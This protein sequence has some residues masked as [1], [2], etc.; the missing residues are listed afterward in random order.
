MRKL[1][2]MVTM[3][4]TMMMIMIVMAVCE[5]H[6]SE[7]VWMIWQA[8]IT[9]TYLHH[10]HCLNLCASNAK[11]SL[12]SF[13]KWSERQHGNKKCHIKI[14]VLYKIINLAINTA[15]NMSSLKA[16]LS[17]AFKSFRAS[18]ALYIQHT[19]K[20]KNIG[21]LFFLRVHSVIKGA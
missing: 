18:G 11:L 19:L 3:T 2:V 13:P 21:N 6:L 1:A 10:H 8:E 9:H 20:E 12:R 5:K 15:V 16:S 14:E 17:N 4:M 7:A